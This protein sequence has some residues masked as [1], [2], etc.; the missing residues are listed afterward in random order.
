MTGQIKVVMLGDS[1]TG[2]N[3]I[4]K[5]FVKNR[6][7]PVCKSTQV[8][9]MMS[10]SMPIPGLKTSARFQIWDTAGQ[11]KFHSMASFYYQ[12]AAAAVVVFD[13]TQAQS[14]DGVKVW[15]KEIHEKRSESIVIVIAGNKA[16]LID[17]QKVS[18]EAAKEYADSIGANLMIV[19]AKDDININDIFIHIGTALK[20]AIVE[21]P[22]KKKEKE[23]SKKMDGMD[24]RDGTNDTDSKNKK[25]SDGKVV[26]DPN[27]AKEKKSDKCC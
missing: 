20:E 27:K 9:A 19:S 26:L 18:P 13:L 25:S 8:N 24:G 15:I 11:E 3:S 22:S 17:E 14:F 6:F 1:G 12:D 4:I 16:D 21:S 5:R 2:K 23:P 7:D 10:K